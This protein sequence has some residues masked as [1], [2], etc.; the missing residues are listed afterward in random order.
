MLN[1]GWVGLSSAQGLGKEGKGR[2]RKGE[3][4]S[5][6]S[7][8]LSVH[9]K[10]SSCQSWCFSR[11]W[12]IRNSRGHLIEAASKEVVGSNVSSAKGR[13]DLE[14]KSSPHSFPELLDPPRQEMLLCVQSHCFPPA[15]HFNF[16][17]PLL[18]L[19]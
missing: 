3:G 8:E 18:W 4:L 17:H 16:P 19:E 2:L 12:N 13:F 11:G 7:A 14:E 10:D 1:E 15:S 5:L 6:G 9:F